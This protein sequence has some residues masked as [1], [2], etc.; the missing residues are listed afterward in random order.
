M[1]RQNTAGPFKAKTNSSSLNNVARIVFHRVSDLS[2]RT[3]LHSKKHSY[4]ST[5]KNP[6][7]LY[8]VSSSLV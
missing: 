1:Y 8:S 5:A 3:Q 6:S 2:S 7:A 4:S